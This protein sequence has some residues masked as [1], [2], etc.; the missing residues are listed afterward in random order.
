MTIDKETKPNFTTLYF[1]DNL[2]TFGHCLLYKN[3]NKSTHKQFV[4]AYRMNA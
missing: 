1:K 3:N 4:M 2:F